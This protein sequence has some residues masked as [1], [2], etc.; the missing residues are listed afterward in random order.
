M[1]DG[2]SEDDNQTINH[3]GWVERFFIYQIFHKESRHDHEGGKSHWQNESL[4][5]VRRE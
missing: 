4:H 5:F 1:I 2:R 3:Q